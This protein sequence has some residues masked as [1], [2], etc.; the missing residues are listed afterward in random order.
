MN[1]KIKF[2]IFA[3]SLLISLS[4]ISQDTIVFQP[5][6]SEGKDAIVHSLH[7]ANNYGA[8]P[9]LIAAAWTYQGTFGIIRGLFKFDL[10]SL[11]EDMQIQSAYLNLYHNPTSGHEGHAGNNIAWISKV[12]GNWDEFAVNWNNQPATT[13]ENQVTIPPSASA[14]QNYLEIPVTD[15]VQD[16]IENPDA[17]NGFQIMLQFEEIYRSLIF[18]SSDH[19]SSG[20]WPMLV[21]IPECEA[22]V[23]DFSLTI[24]GSTVALTDESQNA[25]SWLWDFGDGYQSTLSNPVHTYQETGNFMICLTVTNECGSNTKCDTVRISLTDI[26]NISYLSQVTLAPNPVAEVLK[27]Q[28]PENKYS[29]FEI[30]IVN[31]SGIVVYHNKDINPIESIIEINCTH[32][33]PGIYFIKIRDQQQNIIK[34]FLVQ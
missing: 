9:N 21:V 19:P 8:S 34:K 14:T 13:N 28:L 12:V 26:E 22:P 6:P 16:M 20:L 18:A 32:L 31:T 4:T 25:T 27:I 15:I 2:S 30:D 23:A 11:P 33:N 1:K 29:A 3:I 10:T 7:P 17:N 24:Q 5:G